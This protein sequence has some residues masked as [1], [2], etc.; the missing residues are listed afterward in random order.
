MVQTKRSMKI[1]VIGERNR[2]DE[3]ATILPENAEIDA[4]PFYQNE[5]LTDYDIVFDLN[6]DDVPELPEPYGNE[7]DTIIFISSVKMQLAEV[8]YFLDDEIHSK[9]FGINALPTFLGRKLV[10][11]SCLQKNDEPLLKETAKKLGWEIAITDDRVGMITPRI[12]CM[13]INEAC[14]TVQEG[15]ATMEDIDLGM[16]LGTNY[17]FG[18]FEWAD[19]I[20]I[21]DVYET[22]EA[23]YEDTKDERYKICPLLKTKYMLSEKFYS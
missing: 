20:G 21:K 5:P 23:V 11:V 12:V 3:L 19:K 6:F 18:P 7:K 17:P 13:I 8:T 22:L 2:I 10:E 15:T 1:L 14:F 4:I 16:K 9:I